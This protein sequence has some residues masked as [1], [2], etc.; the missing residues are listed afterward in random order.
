MRATGDLYQGLLNLLAQRFEVYALDLPGH[1]ASAGAVA[2]W[3]YEMVAD[4][5]VGVSQALG[6]EA[7]TFI[8]HSFGA[9]IGLLASLR[10]PGAFPALCLLSPG[11]ADSR[12]DPV[13][14]LNA[15]IEHGHDRDALRDGF[16]AMFVHEPGRL[17][18]L[19]LDAATLVDA[20]VHRAQ[21]GPEPAVF[22]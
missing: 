3:S 2:G 19:A 17:L 10:H 9:V 22:D 6:L 7:P 21:K 5:V 4:S 20:D 16:R 13:D 15:L 18:D 12:R 8:G 11:P 14:T 1:G